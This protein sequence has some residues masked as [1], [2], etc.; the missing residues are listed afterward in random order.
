M[1][2]IQSGLDSPEGIATLFITHQKQQQ[3]LAFA[4]LLG[5]LGSTLS[6]YGTCWGK[7]RE[8]C[9]TPLELVTL[10][11]IEVRGHPAFWTTSSDLYCLSTHTTQNLAFNPPSHVCDVCFP[12]LQVKGRVVCDAESVT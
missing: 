8:L 5:W 1:G 6:P 7:Q 3:P 12:G 2:S 4:F 9:L 10:V 11:T